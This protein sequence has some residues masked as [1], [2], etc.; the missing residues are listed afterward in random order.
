MTA[1]ELTLTMIRGT[2]AGLPETE[3]TKIETIASELRRI[4]ADA[5]DVGVIALALVGAEMAAS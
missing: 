2:I 5:N 4:I 1:E 3:R